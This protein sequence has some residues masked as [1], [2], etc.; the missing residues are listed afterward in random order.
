MMVD[1]LSREM[2]KETK[3]REQAV[4]EKDQSVEKLQAYHEAFEALQIS[5]PQQFMLDY[6]GM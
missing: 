6:E 5:D 4:R 2:E 1:K 3:R